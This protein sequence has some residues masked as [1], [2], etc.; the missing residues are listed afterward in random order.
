MIHRITQWF[1]NQ[2]GKVSSDISEPGTCRCSQSRGLFLDQR[3][4]NRTIAGAI[5]VAVFLLVSGYFWGQHSAIDQVLNAV[6]RD[7]FADQIYYSMCPANEMKEGES[8]DSEEN[9]DAEPSQKPE[10]A[11]V[12]SAAPIAAT[13]P[14]QKSYFAQLAG[15]GQQQRAQRYAQ[16]LQHRGF[17]VHV[18]KRLSKSGKRTVAWYQVVTD[19]FQDK[20]VAERTVAQLK[21]QERLHDI[22][23]VER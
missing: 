17:P 16:Q 4:L 14:E 22:T 23:L 10:A 2:L 18:I 19:D 15:F 7:S 9:E 12:E 13:E 3:Q 11:P 8:A 21:T 1:K 5:V 6:E 20:Q